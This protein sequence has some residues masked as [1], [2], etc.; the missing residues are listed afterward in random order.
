MKPNTVLSV[1]ALAAVLAANSVSTATAYTASVSGISSGAFM[2]VQY[3]VAHSEKVPGAGI[4][5]GGPY[6]CAEDDV[7]VALS[8]CMKSPQLIDVDELVRVTHLTYQSSGTIDNPSNLAQSRAYLFTGSEDSQVNPGV[9]RK[10]GAYYAQ[11]GVQDVM[12]VDN[13]AAEHSQVTLDYGNPCAYLG[14][15]YMNNCGYDLAGD[16]LK[17]VYGAPRLANGRV[18]QANLTGAYTQLDQASFLNPPYSAKSAS[19]DEYAWA[20]VPQACAPLGSGTSNGCDVH[21]SYHGCLQ[22]Y[23]FINDTYIRHAGYNEW[24][25]ANKLIV[26]YPQATANDLNPNGCWDWWGYTGPDYAAKPAAQISM[27]HNMLEHYFG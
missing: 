20:Y 4:V 10:L 7:A 22:G 21:V 1:A 14:A 24:A 23:S 9:V 8:A 2:A 18:A 15:P 11:M 3:H 27:V 13:I 12:L 17:Q 25:D 19:V 26:L 5:A 6:W 16:L